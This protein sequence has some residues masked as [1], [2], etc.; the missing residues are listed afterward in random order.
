[1]RAAAL[2]VAAQQSHFSRRKRGVSGRARSEA[3]MRE[4]V[5]LS[6]VDIVTIERDARRLRAE[7]TRDAFAAGW[8]WLRG[9]LT[10]AGVP[11]AR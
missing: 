8:R 6:R 9:L 2:H 5:I 1:L 11:V 4:P 7:A 10:P 3:S